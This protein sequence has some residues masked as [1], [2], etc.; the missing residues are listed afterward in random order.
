M[1]SSS[2]PTVESLQLL[3]EHAGLTLSEEEAGK[4]LVGFE[5]NRGWTERVRQLL[6]PDLEPSAIFTA[7]QPGP[8]E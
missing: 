4:L 7:G 6:R 5:R 8:K 3:A 2:D 1:T